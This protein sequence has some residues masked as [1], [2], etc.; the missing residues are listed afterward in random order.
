[1]H[2]PTDFYAN[3]QPQ[4][5]H[6]AKVSCV[7]RCPDLQAI[8]GVNGEASDWLRWL[9]AHPHQLDD[10]FHL[11]AWRLLQRGAPYPATNTCNNLSRLYITLQTSV[12]LFC[13]HHH[14]CP[15][16]P[17]L[18]RSV[19]KQLDNLNSLRYFMYFNECRVIVHT[20]SMVYCPE[21][22][23]RSCFQWR[24]EWEDRS[25]EGLRKFLG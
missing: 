10:Q 8:G 19:K 13:H 2:D 3:L 25:P 5:Q 4:T 18:L 23:H 16:P 17:F 14:H 22:H 1:M 9:P 6:C 21:A 7:K 11:V 15:P 24:V 12:N 20:A